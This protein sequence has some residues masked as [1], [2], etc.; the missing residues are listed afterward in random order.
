MLGLDGAP[1][2]KMKKFPV[3]EFEDCLGGS[4]TK[5]IRWDHIFL[6]LILD[7]ILTSEVDRYDVLSITGNDV[8]VRWN[9]GTGEFKFSGS[10]GK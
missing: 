4:I 5:S 9:P 6:L 10:Y 3:M 2:F 1:T 8:N 7:V